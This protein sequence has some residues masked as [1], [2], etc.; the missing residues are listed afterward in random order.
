MHIY[1]LTKRPEK[2]HDLLQSPVCS[3]LPQ[4]SMEDVLVN[5]S[6]LLL[7][8]VYLLFSFSFTIVSLKVS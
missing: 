5:I 2:I 8:S 6:F 1:S 7:R 3:C 4:E